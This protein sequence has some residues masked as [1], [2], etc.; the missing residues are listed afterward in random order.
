MSRPVCSRIWKR[1]SAKAPIRDAVIA[2]GGNL[3]SG[4]AGLVTGLAYLLPWL[5]ALALVAWLVR[6]FWRKV[7]RK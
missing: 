1:L 3:S 2:F 6:Q 7:F 5:F 4:I